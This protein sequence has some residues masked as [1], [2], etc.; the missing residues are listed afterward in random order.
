MDSPRDDRSLGQLFS[1]LSKQTGEL[2]R[3][4]VTLARVELGQKAS[5][6]GKDVGFLAIGGA[7]AYAG[8]LAVIAAIIIVLANFIPWWLSALLVGLIVAGIG[9]VLV[10]RGLSALKKQN[11]APT[12]TL[13]TLKEDTEWAKN[14]V[15]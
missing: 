2:V 1:D 5:E 10:Q 4:E 3:H 9:Y 11:M 14:Q 15:R 13:E 8:L 12:R 7:I 6:V